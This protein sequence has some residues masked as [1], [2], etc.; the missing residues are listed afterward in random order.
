M[1]HPIYVSITYSR[2][3]LRSLEA[4]FLLRAKS[5]YFLGKETWG[6]VQCRTRFWWMDPKRHSFSRPIRWKLI[7]N[8]E[9]NIT[10]LL[11]IFFYVF[12]SLYHELYGGNTP[13][14]IVNGY[15][16]WAKRRKNN[17]LNYRTQSLTFFN[18]ITSFLCSRLC[19]YPNFLGN[20][21]VFLG[22]NCQNKPLRPRV[23]PSYK[24]NRSR[25]VSPFPKHWLL[26]CNA[27]VSSGR[28]NVK[29]LP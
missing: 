11:I 26:V 19:I 15:G 25:V 6:K 22:R 7:T 16:K 29:T 23:G 4:S 13:L 27:S 21:I 1:E 8:S 12:F 14:C 17:L 20:W 24:S 18:N 2:P 9:K 5:N 28:K 3:F 10:E